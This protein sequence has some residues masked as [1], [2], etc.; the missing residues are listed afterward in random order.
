M[1]FG[2]INPFLWINSA[3]LRVGQR[4][5]VDPPFALA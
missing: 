2:V 4:S 5:V 3:L 1:F